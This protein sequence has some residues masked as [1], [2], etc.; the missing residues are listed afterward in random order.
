MCPKYKIREGRRCHLNF[1]ES[2]FG[3][4]TFKWPIY[5]HV[6]AKFDAVLSSLATEV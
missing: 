4:M 3:P 1:T 6:S 5:L 2:D